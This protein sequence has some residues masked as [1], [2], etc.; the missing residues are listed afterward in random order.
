MKTI[1]FLEIDNCSK[2]PNVVTERTPGAG[3]ALDYFC[4]LCANK[5]VMGY[6]E[7]DSDFSDVPD[8]CPIRA[9]KDVVI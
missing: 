5:R 1:I 2:C 9:D 3:Y 7:W 8:W 6:V 4:S